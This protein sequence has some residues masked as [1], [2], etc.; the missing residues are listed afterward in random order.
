MAFENF[1]TIGDP[2]LGRTFKTGVPLHRAGDR[3][4]AVWDDFETRICEVGFKHKVIMGDLF[5]QFVVPPEV[6]IRAANAISTGTGSVTG[7]IIILRGNHDASKDV[8]KKSSFDLLYALLSPLVAAGKIVFAFGD[9]P[10]I[11]EDAAFFGWHPF[12]SAEDAVGMIYPTWGIRKAFGHWDTTQHGQDRHN[13]IPLEVF[14]AKGITDVYTGHVHQAGFFEYPDLKLYVTGSMQ[15]YAHGEQ[16]EGDSRYQ[17]L[18]V[19]E[20]ETRLAADPECFA[21]SNVRI[22][23]GDNETFM[24]KFNCLSMTFQRLV[25]LHK[26]EDAVEDEGDV[27]FD[28][29]N[30]DHLAAYCF[31]K[32]QVDSEMQTQILTTIAEKNSRD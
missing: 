29:F 12:I 9:E 11:V 6:V 23:L 32:N 16:E 10:V 30:F 26:E 5:D 7:K 17:T 20:V 18:S 15:P 4:Q 21:N 28:E 19:I 8:T 1:T 14:R 27:S 31:E 25:A 24:G 2:H 13:L 3:E 22:R